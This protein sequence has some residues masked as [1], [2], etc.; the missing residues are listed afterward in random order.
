MLEAPILN[1][2]RAKYRRRPYALFVPPLLPT[3]VDTPPEGERWEHEIKYDGYRT[4]IVVDYGKG[5]AFTR[6][7]HDW[8]DKYAGVAGAACLLTKRSASIDGE[9]IVQDETGRSD[10]GALRSAISGQPQRLIFMAFD[11]LELDGEDLRQEPLRIRRDKLARLIGKANPASPIQFSES[12]GGSGP[13]MLQAACAMGLEGIVSKR[14]DSKYRSGR[15]AAWLKTKCYGEDE[16]T[17]IGAEHEPGK[18]A[19]A[20]LARPGDDGLEYAGSA[21][22]TLAGEARNRFWEMVEARK[23][24]KPVIPMEKGKARRWVEPGMR[25]RA[26]FLAGEHGHLRH[27]SIREL[28]S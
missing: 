21:F 28:L 23:R 8:T 5:R 2:S 16:F 22:V 13:E 1:P 4:L 15:S 25:V 18:P 26:Q 11:L 12:L 27:A 24:A 7:G 17:V 10:F 9:M 19:F 3:L 14:V 20:L 6:N